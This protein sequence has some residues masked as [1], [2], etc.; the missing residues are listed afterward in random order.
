[1]FLSSKPRIGEP[2]VITGIGMITSV[3]GSAAATWEAVRCGESGV[4]S[5]RGLPGIPDD[6]IIGAPV[7][8]DTSCPSQLKV[9]ALSQTAAQEALLDADIDLAAV[10]RDR[11]AC[12]ISG[13]MGD[14]DGIAEILGLSSKSEGDVPSWHQWMP[15][16]ACATVAAEHQW[17][18]RYSLRRPSYPG[19]SV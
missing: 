17:S 18:D 3:G 19:W 13:H 5:I 11:F 8:I 16:T 6:L 1:M 14:T 2:V 9:I 12:A 15:N 7:D 10:D 4:R